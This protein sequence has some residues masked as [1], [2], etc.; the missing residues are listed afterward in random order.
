MFWTLT[1]N[2]LVGSP[3]PGKTAWPKTYGA[4]PDLETGQRMLAVATEGGIV[5]TVSG[6]PPAKAEGMGGA[7]APQYRSTVHAPVK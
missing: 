4:R 5:L 7:T 1:V 6:P 2:K 3:G